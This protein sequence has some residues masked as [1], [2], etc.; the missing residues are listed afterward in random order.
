MPRLDSYKFNSLS[1]CYG[2][3]WE[4]MSSDPGK[5]ILNHEDIGPWE[6]WMKFKISEL[7]FDECHWTLLKISQYLSQ[8]WPRPMSPYGITRPQCVNS[9][10]KKL[11]KFICQGT[12][13]VVVTIDTFHC[14]LPKLTT[15]LVGSFRGLPT[16]FGS[17]DYNGFRGQ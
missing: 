9:Q 16:T 11:W 2:I 15:P 12:N 8:Y 3:W 4:V 6:F 1:K 13:G 7:L 5:W 17:K 10:R 14:W